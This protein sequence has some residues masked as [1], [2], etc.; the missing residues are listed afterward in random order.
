VPRLYIRHQVRGLMAGT[1]PK[2]EL[3]FFPS[4][5]PSR[6]KLDTCAAY[7]RYPCQPTFCDNFF[8]CHAFLGYMQRL[9]TCAVQLG[10][11]RTDPVALLN[12]RSSLFSLLDGV[13]TTR[14]YHDGGGV[15]SC[16][17]FFRHALLMFGTGRVL[18]PPFATF[19]AS[20]SP[21][22]LF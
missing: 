19:S 10:A 20:N 14:A 12:D 21:S 11:L 18:A 6:I 17:G 3:L 1:F 13:A 8:A 22:F 16:V 7:L 4:C 2:G 5:P 15:L 9:L